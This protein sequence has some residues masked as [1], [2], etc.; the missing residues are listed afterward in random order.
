MDSEYSHSTPFELKVSKKDLEKVTKIW[1]KAEEILSQV[2]IL[3]KNIANEWPEERQQH[4]KW[5]YFWTRRA[6]W[7]TDSPV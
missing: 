6:V 7:H 3:M 1:K 2:D 4:R 5:W